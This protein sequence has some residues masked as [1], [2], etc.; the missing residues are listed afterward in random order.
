MEA[1]YYQVDLMDESLRRVLNFAY[2]WLVD[3]VG[4]TDQWDRTYAHIFDPDKDEDFDYVEAPQ[5]GPGQ[6]SFGI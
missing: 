1:R 4:G 5:A 2:D 6:L 3:K